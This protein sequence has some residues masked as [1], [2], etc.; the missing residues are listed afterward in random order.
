MVGYKYSIVGYISIYRNK[1]F[2]SLKNDLFDFQLTYLGNELE[3]FY[4][5]FGKTIRFGSSINILQSHR[6]S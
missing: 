5:V 6:N 4:T 3:F 1:D 2:S